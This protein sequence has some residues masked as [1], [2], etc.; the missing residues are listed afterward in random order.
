MANLEVELRM[1]REQLD[2]EEF[3]IRS[4]KELDPSDY[5]SP[6]MEALLIEPVSA[7]IV[8]SG[9]TILAERI[10]RH[11]L[12]SREQGVQIDLRKKPAAI[13]RI[14]GTPY[15]FLVIIRP[16]G[17]AE[18]MQAKYDDDSHIAK[19]IA[20]IVEVLGAE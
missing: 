8:V 10:V 15:G 20:S 18:R 13:S 12:R 14:A 3:E 7:I 11:W 16:D 5:E 19:L 6:T 2:E 1:M 4:K 17:K 9:V